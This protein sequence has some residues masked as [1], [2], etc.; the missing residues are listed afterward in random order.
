MIAYTAWDSLQ[1]IAR[2]YGADLALVPGEQ[3]AMAPRRGRAG[4]LLALRSRYGR[5]Q[6]RRS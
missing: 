6:S 2:E 1:V 5:L 3:L 4:T